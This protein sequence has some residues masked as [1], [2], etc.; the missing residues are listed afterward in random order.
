MATSINSTN[1]EFGGSGE[2]ETEAVVGVNRKE[3]APLLSQRKLFRSLSGRDISSNGSEGS[4]T[5]RTLGLF[6][7]VFAPVCLSQF[8]S[9]LFL[10]VGFIVGNL[11]LLVA[12]GSLTLAY[13]ILLFTILSICAI[14]T[15]G[16]VE[17][18]G[19]YYMISRTLGPEFGGAIGILF[20]FANVFSSAL[21]TT[22]CVEGLVDN[23]GESG[24]IAHFLLDG[25]WYQFGYG[26]AVN[27]FN[28]LVCL[29]GAAMF[30]RF[31]VIIYAVVLICTGSVI[32]TYFV[33]NHVIEVPI[34]SSNPIVN[35]T[36]PMNGT[37]TGF[38]GRTLEDNLYI[39][40]SRDYTNCD[41]S[42]D[43]MSCITVT[44]AM[45][46]GVLF[47]GV[48][49]IMAGANMSGELKE[50][51]KSIPRGTLMATLFTFTIY[52]LLFVLTASTTERFLMTNSYIFMMGINLWKPFVTIGIITATLSAS[53]S[54]IIG[55][56]RVL[57]ALVKDNI[58]GR[59]TYFIGVLSVGS[60]PVG[61][62]I[63][64]A[65]LVEF[66]LLIGG[67]NQIAE[68]TSIFFL[69]SYFA[70]NLACLGLEWAS[71]PNFRPTFRYF[72]WWTS[73]LGMIGNGA[74]MFVIS[75]SVAAICIILLLVLVIILHL[76]SPSEQ[77]QWG[78]ISQ[79]LIFHQVRKYLLLLDSR[80]DHVKFW[81]P[82]ML[83]MVNSP[84]SAC[85]LIDFTNDLK[86]SGL[87]VLGHVKVGT[88]EDDLKDPAAQDYPKWMA[89]VDHLKVKAFVEVTVAPSVRDGLHH[90]ARVS[91]LGAMKPNTILM[92]FKDNTPSQDFFT[93]YEISASFSYGS[94][95]EGGGENPPLGDS[96]PFNVNSY[97]ATSPTVSS[98]SLLTQG[99]GMT[100]HIT[101]EEYVKMILDIVNLGK[102]VC[103]CRHF[104]QMDKAAIFRK[105]NKQKYFI[106]VW[107][108]DFLNPDDSNIFG[109]TSL[110]L[111]QLA[112]ILNMVSTWRK[113]TTLRVFLCVSSR[114]ADPEAQRTQVKKMLHELRINATIVSVPWDH[115]ATH[116][117]KE[118]DSVN[119][120]AE[121]EANMNYL[122]NLNEEYINGVNGLI[123][124]QSVDTAV[125]FLYLPGPPTNTAL[126][127]DYLRLLTGIT[128]GL[129]PTIMV[130]GISA[131]TTTNL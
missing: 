24:S 69:L 102:N 71:A 88:L 25:K 113:K 19:A 115:V 50:P 41:D 85:P 105:D 98:P 79:A 33:E 16:A 64:S 2:T 86:K 17:G 1:A 131:V 67:L 51:G 20:F 55:S 125:T 119:S 9:L 116:L 46:F 47:S 21:Y 96:S 38:S 30:A 94:I 80:K 104:H 59:L 108:V 74:M 63:V 61:A 81:R 72:S 82:Q 77:H 95:A 92:G 87:Y 118:V 84:R 5:N 27:V 18:G 112:T 7:G 97:H 121:S 124:G 13:A 37:Y 28:M 12:C 10:R 66:V 76:H 107:P 22:G 6:G 49:G 127:L 53:L 70:T 101:S 54:N 31:T 123:S 114:D 26:S 56:S 52:L 99:S 32:L 42:E 128:N 103:L 100:S 65:I 58:Y 106:D 45:T 117:H 60:N 73:V 62:V 8:S 57:E 43:Y 35:E 68:F 44:Y 90:L 110:F 3:K 48:T 23:F 78:S 122:T 36:H 14:S 93:R 39:S 111:M 129:K 120:D 15:N 83:L 29:I 126:H 91:G 40:Y 34:P 89:L 109:T 4:N 11:G 75:P 130:H